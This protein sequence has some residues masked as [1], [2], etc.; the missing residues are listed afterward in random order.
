MFDFVLNCLIFQL[1]S[2][3][4]GDH[5]IIPVSPACRLTDLR[6]MDL[7]M[8]RSDTSN[9]HRRLD[10]VPLMVSGEFSDV[11][12]LVVSFSHRRRLNYRDWEWQSDH[13]R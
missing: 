6:S 1:A 11:H 8:K 3:P 7:S 10:L 2:S 5:S 9:L 4:S 12:P 13:G